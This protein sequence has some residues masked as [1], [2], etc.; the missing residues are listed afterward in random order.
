[1]R[2]IT[3]YYIRRAQYVLQKV[4]EFM[5]AEYETDPTKA[6]PMVGFDKILQI[7]KGFTFN[8]FLNNE[9]LGS[10]RVLLTFSDKY[11]K[12]DDGKVYFVGEA[13]MDTT[14][15]PGVQLEYTP[16]KEKVLKENTKS[17]HIDGFLEDFDTKISFKQLR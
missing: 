8:H 1:M 9:V 15:E 7:H 14:S 4:E 17:Q 5:T 3:V 13:K 10:L 12:A 6:A 11:K 16:A 2:L